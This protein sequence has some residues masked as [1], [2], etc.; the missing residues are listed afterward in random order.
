MVRFEHWIHLDAYGLK[1]KGA[2]M[3]AATLIFLL[4]E[5]QTSVDK[6]QP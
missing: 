2:A 1:K 3:A 4:I 6:L 5:N